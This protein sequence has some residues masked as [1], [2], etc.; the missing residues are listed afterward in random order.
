MRDFFHKHKNIL[1]PPNVLNSTVNISHFL[2]DCDMCLT[3]SEYVGC[4]FSGRI[5]FYQNCVWMVTLLNIDSKTEWRQLTRHTCTHKNT[6]ICGLWGTLS[7]YLYFITPNSNPTLTLPLHRKLL[8]FFKIMVLVI[9]FYAIGFEDTGKA[10]A[11]SHKPC[12]CCSTTTCHCKNNHQTHTEREKGIDE[13]ARRERG[14]ERE[15]E[16][17]ERRRESERESESERER[18]RERERGER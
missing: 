17:R 14:R 13:R 8:W 3:L 2:K 11:F 12:V 9:F 1:L 4:D 16:E 18:E 6:C 10:C 15:R 5:S 7:P